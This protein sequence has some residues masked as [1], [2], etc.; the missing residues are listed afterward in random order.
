MHAPNHSALR[1]RA[2]GCKVLLTVETAVGLP[3]E[4][5][6]AAREAVRLSR[7]EFLQGSYE[8][9]VDSMLAL[10]E[11]TATH[12][13]FVA[14]RELLQAELGIEPSPLVSQ[15]LGNK[16]E[17]DAPRRNAT[18]S[19]SGTAIF[20]DSVDFLLQSD[21]QTDAVALATAY[22]PFGL[23]KGNSSVG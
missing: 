6:S 18:R 9:W 19:N 21:N 13:E 1:N 7:G 23:V 20:E 22:V 12:L 17:S 2:N 8:E 10:G 14:Y 5:L 15:A 4:L 11:D 16:L 3:E